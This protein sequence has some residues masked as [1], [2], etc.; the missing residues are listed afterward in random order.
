MKFSLTLCITEP[1]RQETITLAS[2]PGTLGEETKKN[3]TASLLRRIVQGTAAQLSARGV[4]FR[5]TTRTRNPTGRPAL[6]EASGALDTKAEAL[7]TEALRRT[8]P[9]RR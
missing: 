1:G 3:L 8:L 6:V 4:T 2:V 5:L 7:V 9:E